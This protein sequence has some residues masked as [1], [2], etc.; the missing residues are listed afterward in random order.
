[1][2]IL[3][4]NGSDMNTSLTL[5]ETGESFVILPPSMA[6]DYKENSPCVNNVMLTSNLSLYSTPPSMDVRLP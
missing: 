4:T 6:P 2:S 5:E 1:M 3:T